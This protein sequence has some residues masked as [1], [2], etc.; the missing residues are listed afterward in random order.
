MA[1]SK[2]IK[3]DILKIVHEVSGE[4]QQLNGATLLIS[5]GAGFIG[6]YFLD[7]IEYANKHILK[8]PCKVYCIDN[9]ITGVPERIV[10]LVNSSNI[11]IIKSD[12]CTPV[13]IPDK[14]DF[15]IHAAGIAS[16]TYY[17]LHPIKTVDTTVTGLRN[18]LNLTQQYDIKSF[19][20]F[21]SSEIY[22]DPTP[23]NIPTPETYNG[24]V[25]C[26][27]P[28]ACYDESKRFG[29]TLCGIYR[30]LFN[31]PIKIIRPGNIYGPGMRL[32]D[33]RVIPDFLKNILEGEDI[34]LLSN[35]KPTRCFCYITDAM[36]GFFNILFSAEN[37]EFNISND[38]QE[39]TMF[40]LAKEMIH[41]TKSN[42]LKIK[43]Q[44]SSDPDYLIDNPVR[45]HLD[46]TKARLLLGYSPKVN[47]R[48]GLS[49]TL[50]WFKEQYYS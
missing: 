20:F 47:L 45:R 16:P 2:I 24:N 13:T 14:P 34:E 10:H 4:L 48:E 29:E 19:L 12:I 15:I 30:R 50:T 39:I 6:A 8:N 46:L 35:G 9:F 21:S 38:E 5:G 32:D 41:L 17:R 40:D 42:K 36:V 33:K 7:V 43:Y 23:E 28:R 18:M 11:N 31:T 37:S 22:G 27:G 1:L 3:E 25:S 26:I 49:R 44:N